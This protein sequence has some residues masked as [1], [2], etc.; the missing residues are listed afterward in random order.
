MTKE[1]QKYVAELNEK[2]KTGQAREHAYRP[3]LQHLIESLSTGINAVNDPKHSEHGAPDFVLVRGDLTAG[4]IETKDMN[5][6]LDRTE[7][8][9]QMKRYL[10]YSNL[11]LTNYL[12]FRFFR[13]GQHYGN[14]I[15]CIGNIKNGRLIPEEDRYIELIDALKDFFNQT[16]EKIKSDSRLAELMGAKARRI[17]DEVKKNLNDN[18]SLDKEIVRIYEV[19]KN[20]LIHDL[21]IG[22]FA[23]MYAQT[24][25]YGL[26]VARYNDKD[27]FETFSRQEA[28]T[29]LPASNPFLRQFFDHIGGAN[30][31]ERLAYPVNELC[32][33]FQ[34]SDVKELMQDYIKNDLWGKE[35]GGPDPVIH[36][37]EDF[38]REYDQEL[39]KRMGAYYT[40]LPVVRFIVRSVD[41]I[42]EKDFGLTRGLADTTKNSDGVHRVQVLDPATGTGTF[43]S[44]VIRSIY[45]RL[46]IKEKQKGVWTTYVHNDLLPRIHGFEL[47]MA[48]YVIAHLKLSIEFEKTGFTI[49]HKRLGIYLTNSLEQGVSKDNRQ[50]DFGLARSI[51][52]EAKDASAIKNDKPIMV[53]IG[54]PPYSVSSSNKGE[55]IQNLIEV[56]KKDLNERNIQP[57]SDDYIK[58]VRFAEHFI[59]RNGS[60]IVAMITNNSFLDGRIHRQMRKH[61]LETFNDIYVLDLH[62]NSRVNRMSSDQ[63]VFDIP[64]G[65]SINIFVRKS[66]NNKKLGIVYH[67]EIFGKRQDKF[68]TL[69]ESDIQKIK[70]TKLNYVEP[71]FF[72]VPKDFEGRNDYER[73]FSVTDL[74]NIHSSGATSAKDDLLIKFSKLEI[75]ELHNSFDSKTDEEIAQHYSVEKKQVSIVRKD[76]GNIIGNSTEILYRPF[77]VRYTLFSLKSEGVFSRPRPEVMKHMVKHNLGFI[78]KQGLDQIETPY[79]F[80][81]KFIIDRRSWSRPG[82]LGAEQLFPLYL[83]NDDGL[84]IP[85]IKKEIVEEIEK[86]MGKTTPENIFDYV[87]ASLH[88][89]SYSE[90]YKEFLKIDFPR[91]P[92]P[93]NKEKFWKFVELGKELRK[94]HLLESPKLNKFITS[95]P[96]DGSNEIEKILYKDGKVWISGTQY[97]GEVPEIVWNF[98]I[99][100]YQ[101]ARKWLKDRKGRILNN[102]DIEHYQ[103]MI[104]VLTETE[105]IMKEI[106]RI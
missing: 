96:I 70:W 44:A 50:N 81:S 59:E 46:V 105:R 106:D 94:L 79:C 43:I 93:E 49:F 47:M 80:V 38:L 31:Y 11:I 34:V 72:F 88:S 28:R 26:F 56:Y 18:Y 39:R 65:V 86:T 32:E 42:L 76:L 71:N 98:W 60:G 10:G 19:V 78:A 17:R 1:I 75:E 55:W 73:G 63:N 84:R 40:P 30:F 7:N 13:N 99:G 48:P 77:D 91:V 6:D 87:Y 29:L 33:I 45:E 25:V 8:T 20:L 66:E 100:G 54:N 58:F 82:M 83:Y 68:E 16:P 21:D 69:N 3:A 9:D 23:D 95:Y 61:L 85:N 22:A 89:P 57:L 51:A 102:G 12:E 97:F 104:V 2:F 103:K 90:K 15:I 74:F 4:Y 64:Q 35:H 36:F 67:S 24:L 92:Y 27:S 5:E 52:D 37:Y 41:Q 101:P 53:V 62:G 14:S